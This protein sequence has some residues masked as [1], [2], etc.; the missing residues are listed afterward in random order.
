MAAFMSATNR[1]SGTSLSAAVTSASSL[2][3][4]VPPSS[5]SRSMASAE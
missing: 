4:A 2:N 1:L 5:E 3:D